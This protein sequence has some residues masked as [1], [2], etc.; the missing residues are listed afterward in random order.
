MKHLKCI[1]LLLWAVQINVFSQTNPDRMFETGEDYFTGGN[2]KTQDYE[3]AVK[4]YLKAAA[5]NNANAMIRLAECYEEGYGV[6]KNERKGVEYEKKAA[7]L[8][9]PKAQCWLGNSYAT[10]YGGVEQDYAE[11][12]MWY[13]MSAEQGYAQGQYCLG[14]MYYYGIGVN[15]DYGEALKWYGKAAEQ[16]DDKA[17]AMLGQ[18][19]LVGEGVGMSYAQALKWSQKAA[20]Q[21]NADAQY[22]LGV[23]FESGNGVTSFLE[24]AIKWY[25]KAAE[26]GHQE[27]IKRLEKLKNESDEDYLF[28]SLGESPLDFGIENMDIMG[29][30]SDDDGTGVRDDIPVKK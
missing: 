22:L 19:Y 3:M 18:M 28:D 5:K 24:D 26:Q 27:A 8:G 1:F 30:D 10:A 21:G 12:V 29:V 16:G 9:N 4:W 11:A 2:G 25:A 6:E 15:K 23:I 17:Q 7:A 20:E 13:R 14:N